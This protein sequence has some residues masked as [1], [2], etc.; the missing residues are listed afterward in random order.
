MKSW[1]VWVPIA[2]VLGAIVIGGGV[3]GVLQIFG[4]VSAPVQAAD[5]FLGLLGE[6]KTDAAYKSAAESLRKRMNAAQ[7]AQRVKQL[8]LTEF[9]SSS[10]PHIEFKDGSA[11]LDGSFSRKG[12]GTVPLYVTLIKEGEAW[13]VTS[14]RGQV[15]ELATIRDMVKMTLTDFNK[16]VQANDFTAFHK[17]LAMAFREQYSA[18]R[19]K[20]AF[21]EFIERQINLSGALGLDPVFSPKPKIGDRQVLH[22]VGYYPST[23]SRLY[24][25]LKYVPEGGTWK[26]LA[27]SV[28]V[29]PQDN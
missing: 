7:F 9:E 24:F 5:K 22:V 28:N 10:F 18:E 4:A 8:G 3:W 11:H 27:I 14:F 13:K 6:G 20:D 12:D 17:T 15:P 26:L 2:V 25:D 19:I 1:K 16:A 29:K 23:P 21:Q